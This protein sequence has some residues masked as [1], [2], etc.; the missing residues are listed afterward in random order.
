MGILEERIRQNFEEEG[1]V[2]IQLIYSCDDQE[3]LLNET[4]SGE[5]GQKEYQKVQ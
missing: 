5:N 1:K 3:E 2:Y 4:A